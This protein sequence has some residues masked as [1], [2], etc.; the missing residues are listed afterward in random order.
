[1]PHDSVEAARLQS[2]SENR[3][4]GFDRTRLII[5]ALF[6]FTIFVM[7]LYRPFIRMEVGDPAIYDY[8]AQSI[9]RGDV[10]YRDV[11]DIK[12]P[13]SPYLSALAMIAGKVVSIRDIIAVRWF[14]IIMTAGFSVVIYLVGLAYL[15]NRVAAIVASLLPLTSGLF[16]P[17]MIEGTQPKLPMMFFG[18]VSLLLIARDR[19][20]WSGLTS[21]LSCLCWQP[22][23]LF[24]G[25]A[26]LMF[27]RYLTQWRDLRAVKAIIGAIVPLAIAVGYLQIAG[28]LD[29]FWAYSI[30][31]NSSVFGP[32]ATRDLPA[33]LSHL[34]KITDRVYKH[35]TEFVIFAIIGLIGFTATRLRNLLRGWNVLSSPELFR[36]AIVFPPLIYFAF[37]LINFQAGPDF[38]PFFPFVGLFGGWVFVQTGTLLRRT[39]LPL[40]LAPKLAWER[41]SAVMLIAAITTVVVGFGVFHK[42][43]SSWTLQDQYEEFK[44]IEDALG[45]DGKIYVHGTTEILVIL[46]RPNLNPYLFLDWGMDGFVAMR[47]YGGSFLAL[48]E[49][50]DAQAPRIISLTRLRTLTYRKEL[51]EWAATRYDRLALPKY[52]RVYVRKEA[53]SESH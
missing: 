53:G 27:S 47:D 6:L 37:A 35:D 5:A 50:M 34:W 11:V 24:T 26:V 9:L 23:L 31:Y 39:R 8:I 3:V 13:V 45:P 32:K 41:W 17:M 20:F 42:I 12:G 38:I 43:D 7:L 28:A 44:L 30:T 36:D 49:D 15:K 10:P 40:L 2:H 14:H 25:V 51:E 48:V 1:M 19:P 29:D 52:E 4:F 16:A 33:A 22:G 46:N 18:M 21:M